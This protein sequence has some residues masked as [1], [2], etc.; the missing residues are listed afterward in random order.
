[1]VKKLVKV[2][3]PVVARKMA[4]AGFHYILEKNGEATVYVFSVTPQQM[5]DL[6]KQYS[7][8]VFVV[9]NRLRF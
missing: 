1:M 7:N 5:S 6:Q 4:T 3:D 9:E 2:V 8:N